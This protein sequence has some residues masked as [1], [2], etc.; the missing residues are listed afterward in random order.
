MNKE[1]YEI[2]NFHRVTQSKTQS[3]TELQ[4]HH[5]TLCKTLWN[6]RKEKGE[7]RKLKPLQL[8]MNYKP[9]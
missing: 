4:V 5:E 7:R 9:I 8:A 1:S 2:I 6:K 3:R